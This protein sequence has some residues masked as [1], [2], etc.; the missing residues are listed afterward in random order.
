[1]LQLYYFQ[2]QTAIWGIIY[3]I[4]I[5]NAPLNS[6]NVT[7]KQMRNNVPSSQF[8]CESR[9]MAFTR[10]TISSKHIKPKASKLSQIRVK[11][12]TQLKMTKFGATNSAIF[13]DGPHTIP[14]FM[15][16]LLR[17]ATMIA[18]MCLTVFA[19][20]GDNTI[21]MK[22]GPSPTLVEDSSTLNTNSVDDITLKMIMMRNTQNATLR[23]AGGRDFDVIVTGLYVFARNRGGTITPG[24]GMFNVFPPPWLLPLLLFRLTP[25]VEWNK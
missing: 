1:M 17:P 23:L 14:K 12:S 11:P 24:R 7:K 13:N 5:Q 6:S 20:T 16:I 10:S 25:A 8:S 19:S 9:R 22:F 2:L 3:S 21:A 15:S 4:D 18:D